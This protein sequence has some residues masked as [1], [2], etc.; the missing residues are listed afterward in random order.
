MEGECVYRKECFEPL[1]RTRKLEFQNI[2]RTH[3]IDIFQEL[4]VSNFNTLK[5]RAPMVLKFLIMKLPLRLL[6]LY[7]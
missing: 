3:G 6:Y 7:L 1:L 2:F 5:K 4:F